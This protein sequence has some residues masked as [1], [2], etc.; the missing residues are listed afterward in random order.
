MG[1]CHLDITSKP[2]TIE[3][4]YNSSPK[5]FD[6]ISGKRY[7]AYVENI[8]VHFVPHSG[9][10]QLMVVPLSEQDDPLDDNQGEEALG[11]NAMETIDDDESNRDEDNEE[12][13]K[14]DDEDDDNE[15][16]DDDDEV[17]ELYDDDDDDYRQRQKKKKKTRSNQSKKDSTKLRRKIIIQVFEIKTTNKDN[18]GMVDVI[19]CCHHMNGKPIMYHECN[20]TRNPIRGIGI[21]VD[22]TQESIRSLQ[23]L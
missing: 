21:H 10:G 17:V 6:L 19:V 18:E 13:N 9:E 11:E 1:V 22:S 2:N 14:D 20:Y 15:N 3:L 23:A 4:A 16:D 7:P 5:V 8:P 12:D